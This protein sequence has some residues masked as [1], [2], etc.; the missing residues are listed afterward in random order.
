M[1]DS[2]RRTAAR[3]AMV[4]MLL[5]VVL[6]GV[7][8]ESVPA[9][10]IGADE[11]LEWNQRRTDIQKTGMIVLGS[12]AVANF[13]VSG[14]CMTRTSDRNFYFHQMNVFWNVVNL[15]IAGFGYMG[16]LGSPLDLALAE[17]IHEFRQFSRILA[18][19]AALDLG[20]VMAGFYLKNR[21]KQSEQHMERL[22]GYGNSIIL[23]GSFLFTFDVVLALINRAAVLGLAD[24][25]GVEIAAIPGGIG[26][27]F[28]W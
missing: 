24:V 1:N 10:T 2:K 25:A 14:Y 15:G 23:Q 13:A 3:S 6:S 20:Y 16:A 27:R 17:T 26:A 9:E 12:W 8:A 7:L 28:S 18:I 4:F 21:G 22:I 11:L 19:N 5:A